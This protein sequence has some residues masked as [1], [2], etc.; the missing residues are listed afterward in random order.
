MSLS[1]KATPDDQALTIVRVMAGVVV[2]GV[3]EQAARGMA[4]RVRT[5]KSERMAKILVLPL[6]DEKHF[7]LFTSTYI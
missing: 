2:D 5:M 4:S 6:L 3:D 7:N 1:L